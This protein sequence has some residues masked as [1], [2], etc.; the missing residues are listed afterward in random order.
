MSTVAALSHPWDRRIRNGQRRFRSPAP[1]PS[2]LSR[3]ARSLARPRLPPLPQPR[4]PPRPS[5][6]ANIVAAASSP[7]YSHRR[8]AATAASSSLQSRP[9]QAATASLSSPT[10]LRSAISGSVVARS[11]KRSLGGEGKLRGTPSPG[12]RHAPA[13]APRPSLAARHAFRP[14][15]CG[16]K[17]ASGKS[18][19]SPMYPAARRR[20][21]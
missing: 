21:T 1:N 3:F 14:G 4:A 9:R 8:H 13:V 19:D 11:G 2:P 18:A 20:R 7:T 15:R 10:P 12:A 6:F 5:P 16:A 17:S